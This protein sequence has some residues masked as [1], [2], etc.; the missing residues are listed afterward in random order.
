[1]AKKK[2][3]KREENVGILLQSEPNMRKVISAFPCNPVILMREVFLKSICMN[4]CVGKING[5]GWQEE[6]GV[7][8]KSMA[9]Q[10]G[11]TSACGRTATG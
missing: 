7:W 2:K 3:K 11:D 9:C 1:M 10:S 6:E 4:V 8:E 5:S